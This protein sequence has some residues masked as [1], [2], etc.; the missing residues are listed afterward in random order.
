[1]EPM[2]EA[3]VDTTIPPIVSEVAWDPYV[4]IFN[5]KSGWHGVIRRLRRWLGLPTTEWRLA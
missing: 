4:D 5:P 2:N 3:E 1:M